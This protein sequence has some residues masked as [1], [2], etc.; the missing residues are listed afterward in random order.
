[1][2]DFSGIV[3]WDNMFKYSEIFQD[4]TPTKWAF[5]EDF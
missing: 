3:N 1:M 2:E 5:V 4:N